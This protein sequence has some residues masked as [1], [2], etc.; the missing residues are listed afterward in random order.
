MCTALG[1]SVRQ[2]NVV[3]EEGLRRLETTTVR[4]PRLRFA[5]VAILSSEE[6]AAAADIVVVC[7]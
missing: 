3:W 2:R 5:G 6:S 4:T 1:D 7:R